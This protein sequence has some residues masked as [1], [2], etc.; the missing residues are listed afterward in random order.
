VAFV[1][2]KRVGPYEYYQLVENRWMDG[3]PRQRVLLHLGRY[4]TVEAAL[5]GWPKE[6]EGLRRFASQRRDK[7]E[8]LKKG[9]AGDAAEQMVATVV[10]RAQ[11]A[12]KLADEIAAKLKR[13]Q[14]LRDQGK[15]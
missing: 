11:K 9:D 10:E 12:E 5:E 7:A 8:Q 3:K 14:D 13:L 2:R 15:V 1:R 6:V 4:T